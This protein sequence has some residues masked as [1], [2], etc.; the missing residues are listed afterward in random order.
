MLDL[1][2]ARAAR[3]E[4]MD[5]GVPEAE[6]NGA[7]RRLRTLNRLY[8]AAGPI[9]AGVERLWVDAG[10]PARLTVLDVGS[11]SGDVNRPLLRWAE[12]NRVELR[13]RLVDV[14]EE[15]C[16]EARRL[17]RGEPRVE[18]M[19]GDLFELPE[20]AADIVTATQFVHHFGPAELPGVIRRMLG[21]SR[22]GVV[23]NDLRRHAVPWAAAWLTARLI[24]RNRCIRSDAPLSVARGFRDE[25]WDRLAS[26][27]GIHGLWYA[28]KAPY[29]YVVVIRKNGAEEDGDADDGQDG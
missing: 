17:F 21:V 29:R 1:L 28:R 8:A 5:G 13:V 20:R 15:A 2:Q 4:R 27:G 11:G 16:R 14:R 23:V 10:R 18:V 6:L 26:E 24:T 7:Y 9:R 19:R 3:S 12:R 25:D 22:I